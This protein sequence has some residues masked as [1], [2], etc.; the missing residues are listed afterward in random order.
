MQSILNN[1]SERL[2]QHLGGNWNLLSSLQR[3]RLLRTRPE[4][5]FTDVPLPQAVITM[6][7][8]PFVV[9]YSC[10]AKVHV[11]FTWAAVY[12]ESAE[13]IKVQAENADV[14]LRLTYPS[15]CD[16]N[17]WEAKYMKKEAKKM[18]NWD[19]FGSLLSKTVA[20]MSLRQSAATKT[21][22]S[23]DVSLKNIRLQIV[24]DNI[25]DTPFAF[26]AYI[27]ELKV[28]SPPP[29]DPRLSATEK[30]GLS[31]HLLQALWIRF[32]GFHFFFKEF[33]APKLPDPKA[34]F[35]F[36]KDKRI[37]EILAGVDSG[38]G[39]HTPRRAPR[40]EEDTLAAQLREALPPIV[41]QKIEQEA[42]VAALDGKT[43]KPTQVSSSTDPAQAS[44]KADTKQG[45]DSLDELASWVARMLPD[46]AAVKD[47][48]KEL[49]LPEPS[50]HSKAETASG[51]VNTATSDPA[52][53]STPDVEHTSLRMAQL[54]TEPVHQAV[55]PVTPEPITKIL[56][57]Q[58][59]PSSFSLM[60]NTTPRRKKRKRLRFLRPRRDLNAPL[61]SSHL[62]RETRM[63][64]SLKKALGAVIMESLGLPSK[65][66]R[67]RGPKQKSRK[68][69]LLKR[70]RRF[71]LYN[72]T[73][74][75]SQ[76]SLLDTLSAS[77]ESSSEGQHSSATEEEVSSHEPGP[78]SVE[79]L[80]VSSD[81][82]SEDTEHDAEY[83]D[84][85]SVISASSQPP[86]STDLSDLLSSSMASSS[87][88]VSSAD[89]R[90]SVRLSS[91]SSPE[92][93]SSSGASSN[94]SEDSND[95]FDEPSDD[96]SNEQASNMASS[97]TLSEESSA[98]SS[99]ESSE[100]S[101]GDS[102]EESLLEASTR[103]ASAETQTG[104]PNSL[105]SIP[106][107]SSEFTS[108][109][110]SEHDSSHQSCEDSDPIL[111]RIKRRL[112]HWRLQHALTTELL[113]F[114]PFLKRRRHIDQVCP[115][116]SPS[117]V[118]RPEPSESPSAREQHDCSRLNAERDCEESVPCRA[119]RF[120]LGQDDFHGEAP[121]PK[122]Q[123]FI[124]VKGN[125]AA[126]AP[127]K[128]R[129]KRIFV[130]SGDPDLLDDNSHVLRVTPPEGMEMHVF[131]KKWELRALSVYD[132]S[133]EA[134]KETTLSFVKH[135]PVRAALNLPP[136]ENTIEV[137]ELTLTLSSSAFNALF[138]F[139]RHLEMFS[140]F[141]KGSGARHRQILTSNDA[142]L[143]YNLVLKALD[144]TEK[145]VRLNTEDE[146]KKFE[147]KFAS[148]ELMPIKEMAAKDFLAA[149]AKGGKKSSRKI[150]VPKRPAH[151]PG[152]R[153]GGWNC[154]AGGGHID[155][156][157]LSRRPST[158]QDQT[159]VFGPGK[160]EKRIQ[161]EVDFKWFQEESRLTIEMPNMNFDLIPICRPGVLKQGRALQ[162][163][164]R[165]LPPSLKSFYPP[166][167]APF[168]PQRHHSSLWRFVEPRSNQKIR[169]RRRCNFQTHLGVVHCLTFS[170]SMKILIE[171]W[172]LF[173]KGTYITLS[174]VWAHQR[175]SILGVAS[176]DSIEGSC[177]SKALK[178]T[179]YFRHT[180]QNLLLLA[181]LPEY[182]S[183][184][185]ICAPTK[186]THYKQILQKRLA[187][188][189]RL[190]ALFGELNPVEEDI[191]VNVQ[192]S[193]PAFS[194]PTYDKENG[195][196]MVR[197]GSSEMNVLQLYAPL[198]HPYILTCLD[199]LSGILVA[200]ED[201]GLTSRK[202]TQIMAP[203]LMVSI[204]TLLQ[205]L[206]EFPP[207][208]RI[209]RDL[210]ARVDAPLSQD[211][212]TAVNEGLGS[213]SMYKSLAVYVPNIIAC[214]IPKSR[215][216]H[217]G[218]AIDS[219]IS[220]WNV[221]KPDGNNVLTDAADALKAIA[222]PSSQISIGIS[223][224]RVT[225]DTERT[226]DISTET[227]S[228][229]SKF[230]DGPNKHVATVRG[231]RLLRMMGAEYTKE[232][233]HPTPSKGRPEILTVDMGSVEIRSLESVASVALMAED[234]GQTVVAALNFK[235]FDRR[236]KQFGQHR[237][238]TFVQN[239]SID[240]NP[241]FQVKKS[242]VVKA[243]PNLTAITQHLLT[244][245]S[246]NLTPAKTI[247]MLLNARVRRLSI[248]ADA[249][250]FTY[251]SLNIMDINCL[252]RQGLN[253]T[254]LAVSGSIDEIFVAETCQT[255]KGVVVLKDVLLSKHM[256]RVAASVGDRLQRMPSSGSGGSQNLTSIPSPPRSNVLVSTF[257]SSKPPIRT[258]PL[259]LSGSK[260]NKPPPRAT[261][262]P[263]LDF[264]KT[265]H[266]IPQ[267][268]SLSSLTQAASS[269][270]LVSDIAAIEPLPRN[271]GEGLGDVDVNSD[272][273][274]GF[275]SWA[276]V[277]ASDSQ[278][279][280]H[281][282]DTGRK[283]AKNTQRDSTV[284]DLWKEVAMSLEVDMKEVI[285]SSGSA[286]LAKL[287][288]VMESNI[289]DTAN[290]LVVHF[291]KIS[292]TD[293]A[294]NS[295]KKQS[296]STD[297]LDLNGMISSIFVFSSPQIIQ[298]V[299]ALV[300]F[301]SAHIKYH[302][303][304]VSFFLRTVTAVAMDTLFLG[305]AAD[306]L[307]SPETFSTTTRHMTV[308]ATEPLPPPPESIDRQL[309][310]DPS[311][312]FLHI[313]V[314]RF[315]V[316]LNI[317]NAL[318]SLVKSDPNSSTP[319]SASLESV[320]R[321]D[322]TCLGALK[323]AVNFN[324]VK[325][326][327]P[328]EPSVV[329]ATKKSKP[330]QG[331]PAPAAPNEVYAHVATPIVAVLN[332]SCLSRAAV[333]L[334]D[335]IGL[336]L[337]S[338]MRLRY[339]TRGMSP[340]WTEETLHVDVDMMEISLL[341]DM[342]NLLTSIVFESLTIIGLMNVFK[343]MNRELSALTI[344]EP[345]A[346]PPGSP[347]YVADTS[348]KCVWSDSVVR[349]IR[350]ELD[351][352]EQK[353]AE[354]GVVKDRVITTRRLRM[355]SAELLNIC[356]WTGT[357]C[358]MSD[359]RR[360]TKD[361]QKGLSSDNLGRN[362]D[363]SLFA[364]RL[365][366]AP[367]PFASG[368]WNLARSKCMLVP[369]LQSVCD[370][371][372]FP[373]NSEC[374]LD[375]KALSPWF[376]LS[377][378]THQSPSTA[379][380]DT[381][382]LFGWTQEHTTCVAHLQMGSTL[383][384]V[385][386]N[387]T[388]IVKTATETVKA[389]LSSASAIAPPK[390]TPQTTPKTKAGK[391]QAFT[392]LIQLLTMMT[393][394][395][396]ELPSKAAAMYREK[397]KSLGIVLNI[398]AP[399]IEVVQVPANFTQTRLMINGEKIL[400]MLNRSESSHSRP[401]PLMC[402]THYARTSHIQHFC[403]GLMECG[404][405]TL[406]AMPSPSM[407][408]VGTGNRPTSSPRPVKPVARPTKIAPCLRI[409]FEFLGAMVPATEFV[410]IPDVSLKRL[411]CE[412]M[413]E[414][415]G[416]VAKP[417]QHN[418]KRLQPLEALMESAARTSA[419]LFDE[420]QGGIRMPHTDLLT[421]LSIPLLSLEFGTFNLGAPNA[422][423]NLTL[424]RS[425]SATA[426]GSMVFQNEGMAQHIPSLLESRDAMS[427]TWSLHLPHHS[428]MSSDGSL[429]SQ[430]ERWATTLHLTLQDILFQLSLSEN[431]MD[432][433]TFNGHLQ[434]GIKQIYVEDSSQLPIIISKVTSSISA[435]VPQPQRIMSKR[436]ALFSS[437]S[438]NTN[439]LIK[440]E[441]FAR[442]AQ[443]RRDRTRR[444]L[445]ALGSAVLDETAKVTQNW[446]LSVTGR[447]NSKSATARCICAGLRIEIDPMSLEPISTSTQ[448]FYVTLKD[449][450][451]TKVRSPMT[452]SEVVLTD[453]NV[454]IDPDALW[455]M[456][457]LPPP[458]ASIKPFGES[459]NAQIIPKCA[460]FELT[461]L[462]NRVFRINVTKVVGNKMESQ[463][464]VPEPSVVGGVPAGTSYA[465][466]SAAPSTTADMPR[467]AYGSV[468]PP[469]TR[470]S[471]PESLVRSPTGAQY[472]RSTT[473]HHYSSGMKRKHKG[474]KSK[475]FAQTGL[476]DLPKVEFTHTLSHFEIWVFSWS[477]ETRRRRMAI[478]RRTRH[479]YVTDDSVF[480]FKYL[481]QD[482]AHNW[483]VPE[484]RL[485]LPS[486]E[487][488]FPVRLL[489][490]DEA[491]RTEVMAPSTPGS[492]RESNEVGLEGLTP[493]E[494]LR[495]RPARDRREDVTYID[496]G[497]M[498]HD[499]EESFDDSFFDGD[500]DEDDDAGF[501]EPT[502]TRRKLAIRI[503]SRSVVRA[504][505]LEESRSFPW[506]PD[507]RAMLTLM[508]GESQG[509]LD[510]DIAA[511]KNAGRA[512]QAKELMFAIYLTFSSQFTQKDKD[513][514]LGLLGSSLFIIMGVPALRHDSSFNHFGQ[515]G[516]SETTEQAPESAILVGPSGRLF[517]SETFQEQYQNAMGDDV[518]CSLKS[519]RVTFH[520][521]RCFDPSSKRPQ[522][523]LLKPV[524][525]CFDSVSFPVMCA[526]L[527]L[528]K[529]SLLCPVQIS[530]YQLRLRVSTALFFQVKETIS[531][532]TRRVTKT[533]KSWAS[534]TA[535]NEPTSGYGEMHGNNQ[536]GVVN[537]DP[538]N[539]LD[540]D[541][542]SRNTSQIE[543]EEP[544]EH[545]D[546][547]TS[548][549]CGIKSKALT[550]EEEE[551]DARMIDRSRHVAKALLELNYDLKTDANK[552]EQLDVEEEDERLIRENVVAQYQEGIRQGKSTKALGR[553]IYE[554]LLG[555][556]AT[557]V[558]YHLSVSIDG[559]ECTLVDKNIVAFRT[560]IPKTT[561][562]GPFPL[563][564][565]SRL[566][567][568]AEARFFCWNSF[569]NKQT[570]V[571]D[572]IRVNGDIT[573]TFLIPHKIHLPAVDMTMTVSPIHLIVSAGVL[574]SINKVLQ[575][576]RNAD[577]ALRTGISQTNE[578][579]TIIN[580]TG[581]VLGFVVVGTHNTVSHLRLGSSKLS[582]RAN[583]YNSPH[584]Q[585]MG[586]DGC[587]KP[588][589]PHEITTSVNHGV[590]NPLEFLVEDPRSEVLFSFLRQDL[591]LPPTIEMK[592]PN[593]ILYDTDR[594]GMPIARTEES[595]AELGSV[596][597]DDSSVYSE[598]DGPEE[599][600]KERDS[601]SRMA[602]TAIKLKQ[603]KRVLETL[604]EV[605]C[606][607]RDL[608]RFG[609]P[610]FLTT[611]RI[612]A[613]DP[614][615]REIC[616]LTLLDNPKETTYEAKRAI[617][618]KA[619][620]YRRALMDDQNDFL[621]STTRHVEYMLEG[622][623]SD[624]PF[625]LRNRIDL[626][627]NIQLT[628]KLFNP[629]D[630]WIDCGQ[631][632]MD[633]DS[634]RAY[635]VK[636]L[637]YRV[638]VEPQT[639]TTYP[640]ISGIPEKALYVG[641]SI[642]VENVSAIPLML[643]CQP[644]RNRL[645]RLALKLLSIPVD[646]M[647]KPVSQFV[648]KLRDGP[649]MRRQESVNVELPLWDVHGVLQRPQDRR[650]SSVRLSQQ[651]NDPSMSIVVAPYA[652]T[653]IPLN[654]FQDP[655][656]HQ[657]LISC[658]LPEE[659]SSVNRDTVGIS[660]APPTAKKRSLENS[661]NFR[662]L[663]QLLL[664]LEAYENMTAVDQSRSSIE[665][666]LTKRLNK[667]LNN[668]VVIA[669]NRGLTLM[670]TAKAIDVP[671]NNN[672]EMASKY[673]LKIEPFLFMKNLLPFPVTVKLTPKQKATQVTA[674]RQSLGGSV[675]RRKGSC[676]VPLSEVTPERIINHTTELELTRL[677]QQLPV[678]ATIPTNWV[679]GVPFSSQEL[680]M[681]VCV[682][683]M[684][685]DFFG[686]SMAPSKYGQISAGRHPLAELR[687]LHQI[688]L[689]CLFRNQRSL[690]QVE[691]L[692]NGCVRALQISTA[693]ITGGGQQPLMHHPSTSSARFDR[694]SSPEEEAYT[695]G[696]MA[697]ASKQPMSLWL[698]GADVVSSRLRTVL[699]TKEPVFPP[700]IQ[701]ACNLLES[702]SKNK[703]APLKTTVK[704]GDHRPVPVVADPRR[705]FSSF[706]I[707]V[708]STRRG[709]SMY[710]PCLIENLAT[711]SILVVG[712]RPL[713]PKCRL[714]TTEED[715]K[716]TRVAAIQQHPETKLPHISQYS[717]KLDYLSNP[718][719]PRPPIL[720]TMPTVAGPKTVQTW[721]PPTI[722]E[723]KKSPLRTQVLAVAR[724]KA[725]HHDA[726]HGA[727]PKVRHHSKQ[728]Q[729]SHEKL[730]SK[731]RRV[732]RDVS[733][734][735]AAP[736]SMQKGG[737]D[738]LAPGI[739]RSISLGM[740]VRYA[741][742][743]FGQVRIVSFVPY[744]QFYSRL[745]FSINIVPS[746]FPITVYKKG[747][748]DMFD[749]AIL[750]RPNEQRTLH[751]AKSHAFLASSTMTY[752]ARPFPLNIQSVP[753]VMQLRFEE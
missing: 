253:P 362:R 546:D 658:I 707:G 134:S 538:L 653:C 573:R 536:L 629:A 611:T 544:S 426:G 552:L 723:K 635:Y 738:L 460:E 535:T 438:T 308:K 148:S 702:M 347:R 628:D 40:S 346:E 680:E 443:L 733:M 267:L 110:C 474:S 555:R 297:A 727:A 2:K 127:N 679:W 295:D 417:L 579:I 147:K 488:Q 717:S 284:P 409:G 226:L 700:A 207:P 240:P 498:D 168:P 447:A 251:F 681:E 278:T 334:G 577:M 36:L 238:L 294:S 424:L 365:T 698:Y 86:S 48:A 677:K 643:T 642:Q 648:M 200:L 176:P 24:D 46:E 56:L 504:N 223:G 208:L 373:G 693:Y 255:S 76:D 402:P 551:E 349:N 103:T 331:V 676:V 281:P 673:I 270:N 526:D 483:R 91:T 404:E 25:C 497:A 581:A 283:S 258:L 394:T 42:Q 586:S 589:E 724:N 107:S 35:A 4:L 30:H 146:L 138:S 291:R 392:N 401:H 410:Q 166:S 102:S 105:N 70:L 221:A 155:M 510:G 87:E 329:F 563:I 610:E 467:R 216:S 650:N 39:A 697:Y 1:V 178:T 729:M 715:L 468:S 156:S 533:T 93:S 55:L 338:D 170:F 382:A 675:N 385:E 708:N 671:T 735:A 587:N 197:I 710:A 318:I 593:Y 152:Q 630:G 357:Y 315:K 44:T 97:E 14:R 117:I 435:P 100:A 397:V 596:R 419:V 192:S 744:F 133:S 741:E 289:E 54:S 383:I 53:I 77:F 51:T 205:F 256:A 169:N 122:R 233:M 619:R 21:I 80:C 141:V 224:F 5:D 384:T 243:L 104:T 96:E 19:K 286:Y 588:P 312:E 187:N 746:A 490:S 112:N 272:S 292:A 684:P 537:E 88:S 695:I 548:V 728:Y 162:A 678:T 119:T 165:P 721:V 559:I 201:D 259:P 211:Q 27:D 753:S 121:P 561:C 101:L 84:C 665:Q 657:V 413:A 515:V 98:E 604:E 34:V 618:E 340:Q 487:S 576:V 706:V 632:K 356:V 428:G 633:R 218:I 651:L 314:Q 528:L 743:P 674:R 454:M 198:F 636:N 731:L 689:H 164:G 38:T 261:L 248:N 747:T 320:S 516:E 249:K 309:F 519:L 335:S 177:T 646:K 530:I 734:S 182:P 287:N 85:T 361:F 640:A 617:V 64:S 578:D 139:V 8:L 49:S 296:F 446:V 482:V 153:K 370:V 433:G 520:L 476:R 564:G 645:R 219:V 491:D 439:P 422:M 10:I 627:S 37:D 569:I 456:G 254:S 606:L 688:V 355:F 620:P 730:T 503:P 181:D 290:Q 339:L 557:S 317:R 625:L 322:V 327:F 303:K 637:G 486:R 696:G 245:L 541:R 612:L 276:T 115:E 265:S 124:T 29:N 406:S 132:L 726:S 501:T 509:S 668:Q 9:D 597:D 371:E 672:A 705:Y 149:E 714:F 725:F 300:N 740:I 228:V 123:Q 592:S 558:I 387:M 167:A 621:M 324:E 116:I 82:S 186:V 574:T 662:Q 595:R 372:T 418:G 660:M 174:D 135:D 692:L 455:V 41:I 582:S 306:S 237:D 737:P 429:D 188:H 376:H 20:D 298:Q 624:A 343:T 720:L 99:G 437:R 421:R 534:V 453:F 66:R 161:D 58:E 68:G 398:A 575:S 412:P 473:H 430:A 732:G 345:P 542:I 113:S 638:V 65:K 61:V 704:A 280:G 663:H 304:C 140:T 391:E 266:P 485:S 556:A 111:G 432:K 539:H 194:K 514:V 736:D 584:T 230:N 180:P 554:T 60:L 50:K 120:A 480:T 246:K 602:Y 17:F 179:S 204:N 81:S 407:V 232:L 580:Q 669:F 333:I 217:I 359:V 311:P 214:L 227:I 184:L 367:P 374:I 189:P 524:P 742:N 279:W 585:L 386:R 369:L 500:F 78:P 462:C 12:G 151:L 73:F 94:A 749:P 379:T 543:S 128:Y 239:P 231:L 420:L 222:S 250:G 363:I 644:R 659:R 495:F 328:N 229:H 448:L 45:T 390:I 341:Q 389:C 481:L 550:K 43:L 130:S 332:G 685:I 752:A 92:I 325:R 652:K 472:A 508:E 440:S 11:E 716:N 532:I 647:P 90:T 158:L 560:W 568:E 408:M 277:A 458:P 263:N 302:R 215:L 414:L 590:V 26:E 75:N 477:S 195:V 505:L 594:F 199:P 336:R 142:R 687:Q 470:V 125:A 28:S 242:V 15:E 547:G 67:R 655:R 649:L 282:D 31:R 639:N 83:S 489:S 641:T 352:V 191:L 118:A 553:F 583:L 368:Q 210:F 16:P 565:E 247:T 69:S 57:T 540:Y 523:K 150:S 264:T 572:P 654:W 521:L 202:R 109:G 699:A 95:E 471:P 436:G 366:P 360:S 22:N 562:V 203:Q 108:S 623:I 364:L 622:L 380:P 59:M 236:L 405:R 499:D 739:P 285:E 527:Y 395:R 607:W 479:L 415:R 713:P 13:P 375:D 461:T 344:A 463:S 353:L 513:E 209:S 664:Y 423:P 591:S 351:R 493:Q 449:M 196:P 690:R 531:I 517:S 52:T 273:S 348:N 411:C 354:Q 74:R 313:P 571:M 173:K 330:R 268:G 661:K 492:A 452:T 323:D 23:L 260:S 750:L 599:N 631:L 598:Y 137:P 377:A 656:G 32:L 478:A 106:F 691:S 126:A 682:H 444:S 545:S 745:P 136:I 7:E 683:G 252:L 160:F 425:G 399:R 506:C 608:C 529:E 494:M 694:M 441:E 712:N 616:A 288:R 33:S 464:T 310:Q 234:I 157:D 475:R 6:A 450:L 144:S 496:L 271:S 114:P 159:G 220:S 512:F 143:Y 3:S 257:E 457:A 225:D 393:Q 275:A 615:L 319:G 748:K 72:R 299:K 667:I 601:P 722:Q 18:K 605:E 400:E 600:R 484:P 465:L 434:A 634:S 613:E 666:V 388:L 307:A 566:S 235:D 451:A 459:V 262:I 686:M 719:K 337:N 47:F 193:E 301:Y 518:I 350:V 213:S 131:F 614:E 751:T 175:H 316:K 305:C 79:S 709:V 63:K 431:N 626:L 396:S 212:I 442:S 427:N 185:A 274:S 609:E 416:N 603:G 62:S 525:S 511:D 206:Q 522:A 701:H 466:S 154:C 445:R 567:I 269:A 670:S 172:T 163:I 502:T 244:K 129:A 171:K 145:Q 469:K 507:R 718:N 89:V 703:R 71:T 326:P 549:Y 321:R 190:Q 183:V 293:A 570:E 378:W 381:A 241:Q 358:T 342:T 403:Y 711:D